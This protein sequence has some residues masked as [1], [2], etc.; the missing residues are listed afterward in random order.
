[1]EKL[2]G[3]GRIWYP[4]DKS[5]RPQLKRYLDEQ[6]GPVAGNVW[7]DIPPI[8]S[9]AAERLGYPTQKPRALLERIIAASSNPGDVVLDP[10]C[11]CGTAID[12]AHR[13]GRRWIGIDITY[14]AIDLIMK[15]LEHGFGADVASSYTV[16]G[17]PHD[18][19]AAQ[20]LFARNPFDFQRWAVSLVGAQ[21]NDRQ[22][23]DKGVDGIA[24]FP[25]GPKNQYG[26]IVV[27]VKGGKSLNP[28]MVRDLVGV[29]A[30][31]KAAM[32]ILITQTEPTRGMVDAANH[33][34]HYTHPANGEMF[35]RI[36]IITTGALL[37]GQRPR[38]PATLLPYVAAPRLAAS[39]PGS[40][41]F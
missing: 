20:A 22:V 15:R 35:P 1:M 37:K 21:P 30:T 24:R 16:S 29:V 36:Q 34:G 23:G 26:R 12:A 6:A 40:A 5:K 2:D 11:G 25:L 18:Q 13:L 3:E 39:G 19:A 8:N 41:L 4:P 32:G 17:V 28:G 10:F 7:T 38:K 9:Q 33:A 14:I 27:S 31:Q